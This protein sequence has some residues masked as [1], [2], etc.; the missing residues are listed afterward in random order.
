MTGMAE[1]RVIFNAEREMHALGK[2]SIK[3]QY[4]IY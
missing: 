4:V 2:H 3:H 1:G